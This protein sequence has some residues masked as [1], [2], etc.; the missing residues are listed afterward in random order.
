LLHTREVAGSKPAAP[1]VRSPRISGDF[2]VSGAL[3][4]LGLE[5]LG[6]GASAHRGGEHEVVGLGAGCG[7]PV[8][9]DFV[10]QRG[11][12]VDEPDSRVGLGVAIGE[13][14][15]AP[16][17]SRRLTDPQTGDAFERILRPRDRR[18]LGVTPRRRRVRFDREPRRGEQICAST[19]QRLSDGRPG[20]QRSAHGWCRCTDAPEG[21]AVELCAMK[22]PRLR[23]RFS[24][25]CMAP[26]DELSG[27]PPSHTL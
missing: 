27:R 5:R 25:R 13:I 17:Q 20:L 10:T 23:Q 14:D 22:H 16:A 21:R 3:I 12:D 19:R 7:V 24:R 11:E 15:V 18:P 9:R 2:V 26:G 1:I 8:A 4:R 6:G